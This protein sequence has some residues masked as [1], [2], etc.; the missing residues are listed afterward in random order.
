M[1][2]RARTPDVIRLAEADIKA[3][4]LET[5]RKDSLLDKSTIIA[6]ELRI[7]GVARRVD[8]ALVGDEF[9]GIEIKSERDTLRR[10]EGQVSGY[11]RYFEKVILVAAERHVPKALR[12]IP[13]WVGL[14]V[15]TPDGEIDRI[16]NAEQ[17]HDLQTTDLVKLLTNSELRKLLR[18]S[19]DGMVARHELLR[20]A[21][22][23]PHSAV[24][25]D[26][27][28]AL[29]VR[30]QHTS[31]AFWRT[32]RNS[33]VKSRHVSKLSRFSDRRQRHEEFE[34]RN[35]ERWRDWHTAAGQ[36]FS[37]YRQPACEVSAL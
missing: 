22:E 30:Y 2:A 23:R 29:R 35:E 8:L 24:M 15:I 19:R 14:Y 27:R 28:S 1:C 10:L 6:S 21:G 17:A 5:L 32:V 7:P 31:Q 26:V 37:E 16:R 33:P 20:L 4:A 34:R 13:W 25:S 18:D 3:L 36:F 12:I 11:L 9:V